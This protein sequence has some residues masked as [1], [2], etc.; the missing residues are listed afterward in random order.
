MEVNANADI[1]SLSIDL[2]TLGLRLFLP[3]QAAI[4]SEIPLHG[5]PLVTR[6]HKV[7]EPLKLVDLFVNLSQIF[8]HD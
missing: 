6:R 8:T 2:K 7:R 4:Y 5:T 1:E 3:R